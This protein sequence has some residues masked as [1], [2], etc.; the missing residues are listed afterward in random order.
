MPFDGPGRTVR[1]QGWTGKIEALIGKLEQ[2]RGVKYEITWVPASEAKELEE[3]A[4]KHEQDWPEMQY[5][6]KTL[7]ASGYGVADGVG[8]L[9]ND[10][11]DFQPETPQAT[12]ER[13]FSSP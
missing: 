6:I 10:L 12:F 9:N 11:F 7:L 3:Q 8:E 5:S 2:A 4:R 13:V 1:V